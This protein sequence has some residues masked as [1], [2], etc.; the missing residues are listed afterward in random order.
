MGQDNTGGSSVTRPSYS[1]SS[2]FGAEQ[3]AGIES[4]HTANVNNAAQATDISVE[5]NSAA[6]KASRIS[7]LSQLISDNSTLMKSMEGGMMAGLLARRQARQQDGG[8]EQPQDSSSP[9]EVIV[10]ED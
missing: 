1:A 5:E 9:G 10:P 6:A 3:S 4:S 2:G 8:N 7:Q